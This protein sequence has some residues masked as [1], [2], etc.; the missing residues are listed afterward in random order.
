MLPL[1]DGCR[2]HTLQQVTDEEAEFLFGIPAADALEHPD[3]VGSIWVV[4]Y[5]RPLSTHETAGHAY[6]L[7]MAQLS[8][9]SGHSAN[10]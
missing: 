3:K 9:V 6:H 4:W 8:D 2:A 5:R 10:R 1:T 7:R